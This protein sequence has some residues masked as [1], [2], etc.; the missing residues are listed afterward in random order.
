MVAQGVTQ[1][2]LT[3]GFLICKFVT[4]FN[5]KRILGIS[6]IPILQGV[7]LI[8]RP[9]ILHPSCHRFNLCFALLVL[10]CYLH[11]LRPTGTSL[12]LTSASILIRVSNNYNRTD[13]I[14][15]KRP[16][17]EPPYTPPQQLFIKKSVVYPT[18]V[19]L[20]PRLPHINP[21]CFLRNKKQRHASYW[22]SISW[23]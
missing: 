20:Q 11:L 22:I 14:S 4:S 10:A 13:E 2:Q 5:L 9:T 21:H 17:I 15:A 19:Y 6:S 23:Q 8:P 18:R 3:T 7:N 16:R 12:V 1:E